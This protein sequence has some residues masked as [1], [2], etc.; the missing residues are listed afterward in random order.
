[1][2]LAVENIDQ[3]RKEKKENYLLPFKNF[4]RS[5]L[6]HDFLTIILYLPSLNSRVLWNR[7]FIYVAAVKKT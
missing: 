2:S 7:N 4:I 3:K 5:I 1:M 6:P